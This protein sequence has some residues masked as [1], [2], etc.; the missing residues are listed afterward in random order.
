MCKYTGIPTYK[1]CTWSFSHS[2]SQRE[3]GA[4]EADPIVKQAASLGGKGRRGSPLAKD[5]NVAVTACWRQHINIQS[6]KNSTCLQ[7]LVAARL[8]SLAVEETCGARPRGAHQPDGGVATPEKLWCRNVIF[9][10]RD[11]CSLRKMCS[12]AALRRARAPDAARRG[13]SPRPRRRHDQR[14]Y[15]NTNTNCHR[16]TRVEIAELTLARLLGAVQHA[17]GSR[18]IQD[19]AVRCPSRH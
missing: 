2:V 9:A 10:K 15:D 7:A 12:S 1:F 18:R 19:A 3:W 17:A 5:Y 4:G 6:F 8:L 11:S 14:L 13:S 16:L